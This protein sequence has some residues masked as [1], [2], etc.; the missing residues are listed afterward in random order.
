MIKELSSIMSD[1]HSF[2]A[3]VLDLTW[4][5]LGLAARLQARSGS[6]L[7]LRNAAGFGAGYPSPPAQQGS[8]LAI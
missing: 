6:C 8:S 4:S 5:R 7:R 3:Q 1:M 2:M